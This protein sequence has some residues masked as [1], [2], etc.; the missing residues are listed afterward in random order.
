MP[1]GRCQ[2]AETKTHA[3]GWCLSSEADSHRTKAPIESGG[4]KPVFRRQRESGGSPLRPEKD[5]LASGGRWNGRFRGAS[6]APTVVLPIDRPDARG[7]SGQGMLAC[8]ADGA[9]YWRMRLAA[10]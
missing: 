1:W 5:G 10:M 9:N 4:A 8:N 7:A 6:L 3:P 2:V